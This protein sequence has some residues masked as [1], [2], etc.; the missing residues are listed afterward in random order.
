MPIVYRKQPK[1]HSDPCA[2]YIQVAWHYGEDDALRKYYGG[3]LVIDG[4][5]RP[6]EFVHNSLDAPTGF[7]WP[8][9]QVHPA[10]IASICHSLFEA[11]RHEPDL[12]VCTRALG[13]Y[14]FLRT[15][16]AVS[17]PF[18][19]VFESEEA[20]VPAEWVWINDTPSHGMSAS[21]LAECLQSR[22]FA[23]E[24][25]LRIQVGLLEVYTELRSA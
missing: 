11:C 25:F 6:L 7:L 12:L 18:A 1:T 21:S 4:K 19:Q 15:E 14:P 20:G 24:P 23:I 22:G 10:A 9:D 5:G 2:A 13:D 17:I 3:L 16:L 8:E